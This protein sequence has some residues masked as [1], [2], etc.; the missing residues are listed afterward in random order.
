M[1]LTLT[2]NDCDRRSS[3]PVRALTKTQLVD[4]I[5]DVNGTATREWLERFDFAALR[6]YLDRLTHA[7]AP[8]GNAWGVAPASRSTAD[9]SCCD[10]DS[11]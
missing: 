3:A 4:A 10:R 9:G 6:V 1:S 7:C 8:R 5:L 2:N 11:A